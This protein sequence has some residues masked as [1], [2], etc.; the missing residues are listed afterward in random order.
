[1]TTWM[2]ASKTVEMDSKGFQ[3]LEVLRRIFIIV[4]YS[5]CQKRRL[6]HSAGNLFEKE[7]NRE[8]ISEKYSNWN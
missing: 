8:S 3:L 5:R 6:K 1:M 4:V 7:S 2:R